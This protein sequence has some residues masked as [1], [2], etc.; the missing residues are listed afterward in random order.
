[1]KIKIVSTR[2]EKEVTKIPKGFLKFR[3]SPEQ[4]RRRLP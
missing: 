2:Q 4:K 3:A 1:M